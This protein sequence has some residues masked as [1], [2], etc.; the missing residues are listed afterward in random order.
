VFLSIANISYL[1]QVGFK[2]AKL[3]KKKE[4]QRKEHGAKRS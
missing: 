3:E 1:V 4:K 2:V